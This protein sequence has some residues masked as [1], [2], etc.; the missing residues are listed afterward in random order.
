MSSQLFSF[1]FIDY[2]LRRPPYPSVRTSLDGVREIFF[3][4]V[5][6]VYGGACVI[7]VSEISSQQG[8]KCRTNAH[9][10]IIKFPT[11]YEALKPQFLFMK[12]YINLSF[13]N[14]NFPHFTHILHIINIKLRDV[15]CP[16]L[17]KLV[18]SLYTYR[19]LYLFT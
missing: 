16:T 17:K 5:V 9:Y 11:S 2:Q 15:S 12:I 1:I 18:D 3:S 8:V 4:S 10:E 13:K 14:E 6:S 7:D 19:Y